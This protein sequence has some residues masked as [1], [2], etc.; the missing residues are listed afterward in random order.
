[1]A[2]LKI[3]L[4]L[5][6]AV[7]FGGC[8][9]TPSPTPRSSAH[10]P[11]ALQTPPRL[12]NW[13]FTAAST[14]PGKPP[15]TFAGSLGQAGAAVKGAF[16]VDGSKCFDRSTTIGM[17]VTVT[18]NSTTLTSAVI[19][20]QVITFIGNFESTTFDGT[21]KIN[22]GCAAGEQGSLTGVNISNIGKSLS[23]SFINSAQKTFNL[24]GEITQSDG[25][26]SDGSFPIT[27]T[28]SFDSPCLGAGTIQPEASSAGSFILGES[29]ALEVE[30]SKSF[31][32]FLGTL[33]QSGS[34]AVTGNYIVSGGGCDDSG[35]AVLRVAGQ[36]DY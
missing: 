7:L 5:S 34:G 24:T 3:I 31:L 10:A 36:W 19:E 2:R 32:T 8:G 29:V 20:G 4:A 14:V 35:T 33:S 13:Q 22:D 9:G 28:G 27:G 21:Y 23:G 1:M 30:T 16:H 11:S 17:T 15:I 18:G 6:V 26:N 25:A 12:G